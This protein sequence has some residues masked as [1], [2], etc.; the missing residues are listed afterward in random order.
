MYS[1]DAPVLDLCWSKDGMFC[2]SGG[3]DNAGRM[4]DLNTGNSQQVAVH[5]APIKCVRFVEVSGQGMLATAG[6]DKKLKV[7]G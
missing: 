7:T 2:F 1:H 4:Y 6:W 3:C 5:D